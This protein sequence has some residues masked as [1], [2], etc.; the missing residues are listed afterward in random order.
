MNTISLQTQQE[1]VAKT[2]KQSNVSNE[3]YRVD[4]LIA[5]ENVEKLKL[6]LDAELKKRQESQSKADRHDTLEKENIAMRQEV[7]TTTL[8]TAFYY[9]LKKILF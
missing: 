2:R 3:T 1:L 7:S 5:E 9:F 4:L 6:R 8:T